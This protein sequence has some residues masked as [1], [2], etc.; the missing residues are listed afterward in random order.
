MPAA[1]SMTMLLTTVSGDA[2][3]F[4][5]LADMHTQAGFKEATA[6]PIP[7]SPHTIVLAQI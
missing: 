3:T 1:F 2:Y 4:K 6:H 5:E 7:M